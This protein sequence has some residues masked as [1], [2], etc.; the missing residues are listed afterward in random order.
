M[1]E[2]LS[3]L[4]GKTSIAALGETSSRALERDSLGYVCVPS[5][6]VVVVISSS[7]NYHASSLDLDEMMLI[8]LTFPPALPT[9]PLF[10]FS[11]FSF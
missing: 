7:Q 6:A 1:S 2:S 9:L 10:F 3:K 8:K 5:A 4:K 11:Y